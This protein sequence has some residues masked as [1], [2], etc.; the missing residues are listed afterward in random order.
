MPSGRPCPIC[1][2]PSNLMQATP[3][4]MAGP[5]VH[6]A[7]FR[8]KTLASN[9]ADPRGLP[10]WAPV[11]HRNRKTSCRLPPSGI[12]LRGIDGGTRPQTSCSAWRIDK[13]AMQWAPT[14]TQ[15]DR[16][17]FGRQTR[18]NVL[19][20]PGKDQNRGPCRVPPRHIFGHSRLDLTDSCILSS[21]DDLSA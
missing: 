9:H 13:P 17:I 3:P 7:A 1:A 14:G 8:Q 18:G 21:I 16:C 15:P 5:E 11:R 19:P 20:P 12:L 6:A 2:A 10:L 4:M